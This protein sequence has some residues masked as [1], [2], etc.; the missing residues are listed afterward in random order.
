VTREREDL[1][2]AH[3]AALATTFAITC[4]AWSGAAFLWSSGSRALA[5]SAFAL[6]LSLGPCL[7][8]YLTA[9]RGLKQVPLCIALLTGALGVLVPSSL[10]ALDRGL[11]GSFPVLCAG[12][13]GALGWA[14][15]SGRS[16]TADNGSADDAAR[17]RDCGPP[18]SAT[19]PSSASGSR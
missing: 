2:L 11:E 12:A 17:P 13:A 19:P 3:P 15:R 4:G 6:G 9:P 16:E 14:I 18:R 8:G 10:A 7:T 1:A 5:L